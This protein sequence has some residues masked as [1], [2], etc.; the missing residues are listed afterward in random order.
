MQ[1]ITQCIDESRTRERPIRLQ[2]ILAYINIKG[3]ADNAAKEATGWRRVERKNGKWRECNFRQTTEMLRRA[4]ATIKLALEQ[5]TL[6]LWEKAWSSDK[7]CRK[8]DAICLEPTKKTLKIHKDL[9]KAASVLVVQMRTEKIGLQ[10]F[11]HSRKGPKFYSPECP[12]G[13]GLQSGKNVLI[14]CRAR[15]GKRN[16]FGMTEERRS[17]EGQD[18]RRY[19][20]SQN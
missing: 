11:P 14:D 12:F 18:G 17:S 3:E 8:L 16:R 6:K 13:R 2:W 10:N 5:K 20:P 1:T 19:Q 9:C 4:R 15:I 7:I